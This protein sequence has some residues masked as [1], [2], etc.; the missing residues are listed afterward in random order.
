MEVPS[1]GSARVLLTLWNSSEIN[2]IDVAKDR[3][4]IILVAQLSFIP[5][6][7]LIVYS[8]SICADLVLLA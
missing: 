3:R 6:Q 5:S 4:V 8:Y 7:V 1:V 2:V